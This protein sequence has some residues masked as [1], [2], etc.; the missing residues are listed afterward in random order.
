[1]YAKSDGDLPVEVKVALVAV[2]AEKKNKK[3]AWAKKEKATVAQKLLAKR[4][5][6]VHGM[7]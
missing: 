5:G 2:A 1:M 4:F 6:K 3:G 7:V